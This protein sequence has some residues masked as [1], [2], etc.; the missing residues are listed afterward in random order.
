MF[1]SIENMFTVVWVILYISVSQLKVLT[2]ATISR[3]NRSEL[4]SYIGIKTR[5]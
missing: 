3:Y 2:P 5:G 1:S 4:V